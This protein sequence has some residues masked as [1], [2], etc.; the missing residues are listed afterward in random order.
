M[1]CTN[2]TKYEL[3]TTFQLLYSY[4]YQSFR[5]PS[6]SSEE[7]IVSSRMYTTYSFFR[8]F[9][10]FLPLLIILYLQNYIHSFIIHAITCVIGVYPIT[11]LSPPSP[12]AIFKTP[13]MKSNDPIPMATTPLYTRLFITVSVPLESVEFL[14]TTNF[15]TSTNIK[16]PT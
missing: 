6:T 2:Q 9:F 13:E 1:N 14:P 7:D 16:H 11:F 8:A 10:V 3:H 15:W 4:N 5:G 12:L